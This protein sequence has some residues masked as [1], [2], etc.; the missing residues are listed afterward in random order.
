MLF[1]LFFPTA[2]NSHVETASI[3]GG[4]VLS[5]VLFSVIT[6]FVYLKKHTKKP[7]EFEVESQRVIERYWWNSMMR[8]RREKNECHRRSKARCLETNR[9]VSA[10]P[11]FS[12]ESRG[13]RESSMPMKL[14]CCCFLVPTEMVHNTTCPIDDGEGETKLLEYSCGIS[15]TTKWIKLIQFYLPALISEEWKKK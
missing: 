5:L 12:V 14:G 4:A 6:F 10:F 7:N 15:W 3:A 1:Y 11:F 9:E 2:G 8:T 13:H